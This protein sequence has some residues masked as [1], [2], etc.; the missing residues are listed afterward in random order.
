MYPYRNATF[1]YIDI[2]G[3]QNK[4]ESHVRHKPCEPKAQT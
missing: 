2:H 4:V 1:A 3:I